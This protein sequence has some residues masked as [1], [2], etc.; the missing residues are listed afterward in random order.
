MINLKKKALP[1]EISFCIAKDHA[2]DLELHFRKQ[3]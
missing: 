2:R 3:E 1:K